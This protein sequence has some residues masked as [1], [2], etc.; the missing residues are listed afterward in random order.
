LFN[1]RKSKNVSSPQMKARFRPLS[2]PLFTL[3]MAALVL[4]LPSGCKKKPAAAAQPDTVATDATNAAPD[5]TAN[6][7]PTAPP[8][9]RLDLTPVQTSIRGKDYD[10]AAEQLIV[11]QHSIKNPTAD[12]SMA[13]VNQMH[14]LQ[15][16]M[17]TAPPNDPKVKLA[18]Q[19][20]TAG[21]SGQ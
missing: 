8:P 17:A 16:A 12:Q 20:L 15:R 9:P 5:A 13:L 1:R 18:I 14:A 19:K 3:L 7:Q 10:K 6:A 2:F 21:M 4:V 11:M